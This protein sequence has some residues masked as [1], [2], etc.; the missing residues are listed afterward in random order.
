M[1][2][3]PAATGSARWGREHCTAAVLTA[4]LT[5]PASANAQPSTSPAAA[6]ETTYVVF[7]A[8]REVG[9]EQVAVSRTASGWN[10]I[11]TGRQGAP[12]NFINN[13]FELTCTPEWQP[14]ELKVDAI[15]Q[16]APIT[17]TTSFAATTATNQI[18]QKGVPST[19]T[20]QVSAGT[21]V[22]PNNFYAAY[23]VLAARLA[24]VAEGAEL[25]IYVAPQAEI[26]VVVRSITP[27]S[28]QTPAGQVSTRRYALTFQNPGG[29]L[30]AEI[31]VDDRNRFAK[32]DIAAGALSVA[33]LDLAGV[34][35]RQQT[36]RNPTDA[37][38]TVPAA[39][40]GL[41][42]T[43][44][45]PRGAATRTKHPAILLVGGATAID[46]DS[47]TAGL[48]V[49]A[50]LAG[51][52]ADLGY[53][54]LRYDK[55]GVGQ[56]G[57]RI[58]T[59]TLQDYADDAIGAV[60]WLAKRKD[61]DDRR[62]AIAGH[63]DG[64]A[65]ALLAA[66]REKKVS[67]IVSIGGMGTTGRE[68]VL[69]QQQQMLNAMKVADP[70][71]TEKIE[72]QKKILEAA[73]SE[74]GWDALPPEVRRAVD[75]RLYRSLLT[76][77]PAKV[78]PRIKQPLLVLQGALDMQVAPHHAE[79]LAA[80][81][82]ARKNAPPIEMKQFAGVNHFMI[83]TAPAHGAEGTSTEAETISA[84]IPKAIASWLTTVQAPANRARAGRA[85]AVAHSGQID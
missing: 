17:L 18:T 74:Q 53:V 80:L 35:T 13:R 62:I 76:F 57:G 8:G 41:A 9:R 64:A 28:Y 21:I 75:T 20:D 42:G 5:F 69:E 82:K 84:D 43:L 70:E 60:K 15:V 83:A 78:M 30:Q 31:T 27:S 39:G 7:V 85:T 68:L 23:E 61:V 33:R 19:K 66:A 14:I 46:R 26:R 38:V 36:V 49:F 29:A 73:V 24:S 54:V 67:A 72:L 22:L 3:R 12:I 34:A 44:T 59:V 37:D 52:L 6:G 81:A 4:F 16:D 65:V 77:D 47:V 45:T 50:Q 32:L 55:R 71:R 25:P 1:T 2:S 56:S 11:S 51:Q 79:R 63:G 48:P 58:E 10:I 40:F